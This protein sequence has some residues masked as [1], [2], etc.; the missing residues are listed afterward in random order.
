MSD[1]FY[2]LLDSGNDVIVWL[3]VAL[4]GLISRYVVAK[5]GSETVRKY[6]GRALDEVYDAVGEV[7]QTFVSEIKKGRADGQLTDEEKAEAKAKA[8]AIAKSNIGAKGLA[9][10]GR[11]LGVDIDDWLGTKVE[12]SVAKLKGP[13]SP[14]L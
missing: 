13:A 5:I 9:R 7:Y 1:I 14:K 8:I 12:A 2:A 11:I 4:V 10:L 6:V 3:A